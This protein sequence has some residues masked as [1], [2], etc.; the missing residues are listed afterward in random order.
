MKN[1]IKH[2]IKYVISEIKIF[3]PEYIFLII[4]TV[5]GL[6]FLFATAPLQAFDETEHFFRSYQVSEL[7]FLSN[8]TNAPNVAGVSDGTGYGGNIPVSVV[9]TASSLR[10]GIQTESGAKK[11]SFIKS[12][13]ITGLKV[14]LNSS[15]KKEVRFDNTAIYS[16][17]GYIPQS[18]GIEF[19]KIL[20]LGPV[21]LIYLGRLANLIVWLALIFV[22]IRITPVGKWVFGAIALNPASIFLAPT[23]SPD[24][25]ASGVIALSVA[26]VLYWR[27]KDTKLSRKSVVLLTALFTT[28]VLIKNVYAPIALILLT[29]PSSVMKNRLKVGIIAALALASVVWNIQVLPVTSGIPSYFGVAEHVSAIDQIHFIINNF[30]SFIKILAWNIIGSPSVLVPYQYA[31]VA[32]DNVIPYWSVV[33]WMFALVLTFLIRS[34]TIVRRVVTTRLRL[35]FA[36]SVVLI[37]IAI[38]ISLYLGW[39]PVGSKMM[40]GIQGRYFIPI[41]FILMPVFINQGIYINDSKK[42]MRLAYGAI[43]VSIVGALL[44]VAIRYWHGINT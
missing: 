40:S 16:P 36:S 42:A 1:N 10:W 43:A 39:S 35:I 25:F 37:A 9:D 15:V 41:S 6:C 13:L 12:R 14:P 29:L 11:G 34:E 23:L 30:Y 28:L 17:A 33:L 22:A 21:Y 7:D 32:A 31:S 44:V 26:L 5:F 20:N 27:A 18:L 2:L 19:G 24:T 8:K 4:G 3:S 38:M